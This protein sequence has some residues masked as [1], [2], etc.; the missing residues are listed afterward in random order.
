LKKGIKVLE[1]NGV[2]I[3]RDEWLAEAELAEKSENY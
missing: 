2:K 1:K 3:V